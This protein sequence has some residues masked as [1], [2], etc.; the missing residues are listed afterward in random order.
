MQVD[1]AEE[2][3]LPTPLLRELQQEELRQVVQ[4]GSRTPLVE[5]GHQH[6]I[7]VGMIANLHLEA[8][9]VVRLIAPCDGIESLSGEPL[10]L[11]GRTETIELS[12]VDA[13]LLGFAAVEVRVSPRIVEAE[14]RWVKGG[15]APN[16]FAEGR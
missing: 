13:A 1:G 5:V 3:H 2:L 12:G 16:S 7:Q 9:P 14:G 4:E 11:A 8:L 6:H 10:H 15:T